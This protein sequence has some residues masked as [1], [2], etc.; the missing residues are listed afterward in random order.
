[1]SR[2]SDRGWSDCLTLLR[3]FRAQ[4]LQTSDLF[5][6]CYLR[7]Y[8]VM[9]STLMAHL[10]S[11]WPL[12]RLQNRG[13]RQGV[14]VKEARIA[15]DQNGVLFAIGANRARLALG[16]QLLENLQLGRR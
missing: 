7:M 11:P 13:Q 8:H 9:S 10:C 3:D 4:Q 5:L 16:C 15:G 6:Y 2:S 12:R 1:M 14:Q